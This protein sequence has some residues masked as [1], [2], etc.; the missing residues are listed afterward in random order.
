MNIKPLDYR[1]VLKKLPETKHLLLGNGFSIAC[2]P[3]F[4]YGNLFEYVKQNGLSENLI[5]VFEYL[6]INNFEGVMRLLDDAIWLRGHYKLIYGKRSEFSMEDD[7]Q[8]IKEALVKAIAQKHLAHSNLIDR[9]RRDQCV[10]FIEPYKTVFTTNYDLLLYWIARHGSE[11]LNERDGFRASIDDPAAPYLV[12]HEHLGDQKGI[13]FLH[14]GLHIYIEDGEIRKHSWKRTDI[15]II[16]LVREGLKRN[17]YPHFVA[18]GNPDKKLKQIHSSGYL[19]YCLGKLERIQQALVIFGLSLGNSDQH[20][21]N[22]ISDN[23]LLERLYIGIFGDPN[24]LKNKSIIQS[25]E[26]MVHRRKQWLVKMKRGKELSIEFY[27]SQT[28]HVWD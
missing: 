11:K 10:S 9:R 26:Y 23:L 13:L 28:A 6:G 8:T 18:E 14:G 7:L 20:I 4:D 24:D 16:E 2:D 15:P 3:I 21:L 5:K 19:T 22:A 27:N 1:D 17:Q 12:F 25:T